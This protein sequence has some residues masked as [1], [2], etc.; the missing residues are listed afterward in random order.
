MENPN[1]PTNEIIDGTDNDGKKRHGCVTAWL[2]LMIVANSAVAL[3]YLFAGNFIT[4][5]SPNSMSTGIL[6]LLA[7]FGIANVIFAVLLLQWKKWGFFGF[8]ISAIG[9]LI[10]NLSIGLSPGQSL[11]GLVGIGVLYGV[12]QIKQDDVSAWDNLE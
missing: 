5:Y 11:L 2:V 6:I 9:S 12:L 7:L 1:E 3:L 8:V 4:K 10:I